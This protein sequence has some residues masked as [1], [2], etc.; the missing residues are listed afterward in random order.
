MDNLDIRIISLLQDDGTATNAGIARQVG[1]SEETVRRRLKRLMQEEYIRVIALPDPAKLGF[2]SEVLI[3]IQVDADK[4]DRVADT[5]ADFDEIN[6]VSVT[7]GSFD[8]FVWATLRSSEELSSF[9]RT[10]V[11]PVPGVRKMET[12]INLTIKKRRYGV[13]I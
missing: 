2:N 11:G 7:T 12:F 6:W 9:L 8:I 10:K 3:G 4:I 5:L 1:V 13:A